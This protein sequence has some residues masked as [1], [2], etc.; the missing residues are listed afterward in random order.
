MRAAL[1][2]VDMQNDFLE[3][4]PVLAAERSRLVEHTNLL[5]RGFRAAEM[6][7]IWIRQE[8]ASDLHDAFLAMRTQNI[9]ITIAGTPGCEILAD[10]DRQPDDA[11]VVKKRYSGFFGTD[12]RA[13][14]SSLG[15]TTVVLAGVNSHACVRMTAIDAYQHDLEVLVAAECVSSYD[16][17]HHDVTL[18]YLGGQIGNVLPNSEVLV[19]VGALSSPSA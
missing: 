6:P 8:F 4:N 18:R 12:L 5:I 3:H 10:L 2:V 13:R 7:I 1:L 16:R 9:S 15:I 17:E 19:R 11:V 14:L